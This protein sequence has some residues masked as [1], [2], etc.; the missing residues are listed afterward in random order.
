MLNGGS[1]CEELV[2][3]SKIAA[4]SV[5]GCVA[6]PSVELPELLQASMA[7]KMVTIAVVS[8]EIFLF[9]RLSSLPIRRLHYITYL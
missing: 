3:V 7:A 8:L 9:I 1:A 5:G 6:V 2:G 4:N